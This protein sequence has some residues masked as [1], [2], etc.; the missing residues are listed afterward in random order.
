MIMLIIPIILK[1]DDFNNNPGI[2]NITNTFL[3]ARAVPL[4][5]NTRPSS[6]IGMRVR[7]ENF[8]FVVKKKTNG[9][10]CLG[11]ESNYRFR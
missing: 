10:T 3:Y 1:L 2:Q 9:D 6:Y 4:V 8:L 7:R 11:N 5:R